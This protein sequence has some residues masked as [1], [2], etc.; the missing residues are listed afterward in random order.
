MDKMKNAFQRAKV[1]YIGRT[2]DSKGRLIAKHFNKRQNGTLPRPIP[3]EF[4]PPLLAR[5]LNPIGHFLKR[6]WPILLPII[7]AT[8]VA[9]F[10]HFDSKTDSKAKQKKEGVPSVQT[11]KQ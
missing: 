3:K 8:I 4:E 2:D 1:W 5:I 6:R 9:L 10:I 7:V 11:G